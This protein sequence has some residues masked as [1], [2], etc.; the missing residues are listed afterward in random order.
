MLASPLTFIDEAYD[1]ATRAAILGRLPPATREAVRSAKEVEW[2]PRHQLI[3]IYRALAEHHRDTDG[4][5]AEA[6]TRMG[7]ASAERAIATFLALVMKVMTVELFAR[8]VPEIWI[9]D[10][11]GGRLEVDTSNLA[12]KHLIYRLLDVKGY[13]YIGAA[14]PGF[15]SVVLTALGCKDLTTECDWKVADP[16]P[17]TVTCHF[18]WS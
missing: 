9:R 17:E 3:A 11:R 7:K 1:E 2:Y 13:E 6:F 16:G 18:R 12:N 4:K 10:H 5:V 15:Q 8:K 14:L